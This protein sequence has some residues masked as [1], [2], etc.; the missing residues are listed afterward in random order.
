RAA[1]RHDKL[2]RVA[3]MWEEYVAWWERD[4]RRPAPARTFAQSVH[5]SRRSDGAEP[6]P[7]R[8]CGS[9]GGEIRGTV[10][11]PGD[12]VIPGARVTATQSAR[13]LAVYVISNADGAYRLCGLQSGRYSLRGELPGFRTFSADRLS[14]LSGRPIWVPVRLEVATMAETVTVTA[15]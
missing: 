2:E 6:V 9:G 14:V 10:V 5:G 8:G 3:A 15:A 11:D 13:G 12:G 7:A 4:F 1:E